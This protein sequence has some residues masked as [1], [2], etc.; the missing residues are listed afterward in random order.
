MQRPYWWDASTASNAWPLPGGHPR[1]GVRRKGPTL[2]AL[3]LPRTVFEE[4][5]L[6]LDDEDRRRDNDI[7]AS[8]V[9]PTLT[10]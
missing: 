4:A 5:E 8:V 2:R 3:G 9:V 7:N 10:N 6:L 1:A